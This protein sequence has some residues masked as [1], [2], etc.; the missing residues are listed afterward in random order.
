M[1]GNDIG[2]SGATALANALK[3]NNTLQWINLGGTLVFGDN[4]VWFNGVGTV[5][6]DRAHACRV[7]L[8]LNLTNSKP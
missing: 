8:A 5:L 7:T 2:P 3:V 1:S 6:I 4:A